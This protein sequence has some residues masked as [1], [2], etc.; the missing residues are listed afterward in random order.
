MTRISYINN[1][2]DWK[3]RFSFYIPINVRFSEVDMFGHL[4]N[5]VPFVYFEEG[6][7]EF[8][9]YI[10]F[11]QKWLDSNSDLIPVVAD[12]Q[13]DFLKQVYLND[14]L[15]LYVKSGEVG[16][17]SMDLLYMLLNGVG[18][19]ALTGRGRMVQISRKTG[20]SVKWSNDQKILLE[21]HI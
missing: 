4:N 18:E 16:G 7:I 15:K 14:E 3:A 9:K 8:F 12:L 6:R 1:L 17:S 11:M 5:T 21:E 10:G 13:C 19:V 20:K 2:Q